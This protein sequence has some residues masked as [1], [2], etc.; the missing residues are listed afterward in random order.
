[1]YKEQRKNLL[2][3]QVDPSPILYINSLRPSVRL[4]VT[5][6]LAGGGK[7]GLVEATGDLSAT[8][9]RFHFHLH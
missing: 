4:S 7:G 9:N 1:M 3:L 5:D 6:V 2:C 8:G